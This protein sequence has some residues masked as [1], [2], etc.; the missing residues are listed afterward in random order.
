VIGT[1][2]AT[3]ALKVLLG[4]GEPLIGRLL[5]Y[6]ALSMRFREFKFQKDPDCPVCGEHP[7]ITEL[8]DYEEFCGVPA[9]DRQF[10]NPNPKKAAVMAVPEISVAEYAK[11]RERGEAHT[12]IDVREPHE[13]QAAN[14]GGK[15]IPLGTLPGRVN[16]IPREGRVIL[17]CRSGARSARAAEY[18]RSLGYTNVENLAGGIVAWARDIDKNMRGH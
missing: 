9:H 16:E 11:L 17:Q 5:T 14:L 1:L 7:T 15:L 10:N 13:Y 2:Q 18:L 12:L 8:I 4:I 6:D 3:E